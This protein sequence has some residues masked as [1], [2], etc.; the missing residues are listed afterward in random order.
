MQRMDFTELDWW[1]KPEKQRTGM[2]R[3]DQKS[4]KMEHSKIYTCTRK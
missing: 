4:E 2:G 3:R 1:L